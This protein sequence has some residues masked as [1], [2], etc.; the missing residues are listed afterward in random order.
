MR[1]SNKWTAWRL[2]N[3]RYALRTDTYSSAVTQLTNSRVQCTYFLPSTCPQKLSRQPKKQT[4]HR[5]NFTAFAFSMQQGFVLCPD[6]DSD[7]GL[8][9]CISEPLFLLQVR[10]GSGD[11]PSS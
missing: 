10:N 9:L 6:L 3:L 1:H 8:I 5:M 7:K 2:E 11:G 4:A